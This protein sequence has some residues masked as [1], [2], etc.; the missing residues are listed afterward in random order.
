MPVLAPVITAVRPAW[1]GTSLSVHVLVVITAPVID[2][3]R[4]FR[5]NYTER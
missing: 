2:S 1:V 4:T 5:L 3:G